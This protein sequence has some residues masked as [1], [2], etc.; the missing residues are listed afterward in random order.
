MLL[1]RIECILIPNFIKIDPVASEPTSN[2]KIHKIKFYFLLCLF[3]FTFIF[4][5]VK[6]INDKYNK[7]MT[8]YIFLTLEAKRGVLQV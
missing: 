7:S 3:V 1:L 5:L 2:K 8:M 6:W 4:S